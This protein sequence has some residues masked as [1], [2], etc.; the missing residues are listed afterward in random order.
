M[1]SFTYCN[2]TGMHLV[3]VVV[4]CCVDG[5]NE[6]QVAERLRRPQWLHLHDA[7]NRQTNNPT[8]RQHC[9]KRTRLPFAPWMCLAD[10]RTNKWIKLRQ[11]EAMCKADN[12]E[13]CGRR[14]EEEEEADRL[15]KVKLYLHSRNGKRRIRASVIYTR[16][17]ISLFTSLQ[18]L[19]AQ[20]QC[21]CPFHVIFVVHMHFYSAFACKKWLRIV[22]ARKWLYTIF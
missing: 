2:T 15:A 9:S 13:Q 3:R 6:Y 22:C 4:S 7:H 16:E 21:W 19:N 8:Y 12:A 10:G 20:N 18:R 14:K 1:R 11:R 5:A 17:T